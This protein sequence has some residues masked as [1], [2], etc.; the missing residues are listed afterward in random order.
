MVTT[1]GVPHGSITY[2]RDTYDDIVDTFEE[3][4]IVGVDD[5]L[6]YVLLPGADCSKDEFAMI[7]FF[8]VEWFY[9]GQPPSPAA[10]RRLA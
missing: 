3:D 8:V 2:L 10:R 7:H 1:A 6:T 4:G 9:Y 5:Q